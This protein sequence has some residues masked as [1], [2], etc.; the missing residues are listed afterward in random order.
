MKYLTRRGSCSY[1]KLLIYSF[2]LKKSTMF[3]AYMLK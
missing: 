2:M 3:I 1:T